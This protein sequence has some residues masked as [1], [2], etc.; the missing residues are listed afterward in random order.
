MKEVIFMKCP[1]VD[2]LSRYADSL[3]ND[4]EYNE[5]HIHVKGCHDCLHVVKAFEA[6]QLFLKE[7]LQT[8]S[9]PDDFASVILDQVEPYKPVRNKKIRWKP[10]L[11]PAAVVILTFGL[12]ASFSPSFAEWIGGL[13]ATEKVDEGLQIASDAGFVKRV[14]LEVTDKNVTFK[15][16]DV[17]ADS[18][19]VAFSYQIL[20]HASK[21]QDTYLDFG[22][23]KNEISAFD[24]N[25]NMLNISSMSWSDSDEY[26]LIEFSLREQESL[27]KITLKLN[28]VEINGVKGQWELD[29][30]VDLKE[31]LEHTTKL[32]LED[33]KTTHHGV[34]VQMKE[35]RFAPSSN[36]IIYETAF[37][38][39]E[40]VKIKE[41][42]QSLEENFG[43]ENVHSFTQYGT[44]IQYHLEDEQ[45][46]PIYYHNSFIDGKGHPSNLGMLQG[47]G[48]HTG[49]FG[50]TKWNESFIPAEEKLTFV[51]DGVI[52]TVPSDFSITIKP[53]ELKKKPVSFEYE[54]N[55]ITISDVK[56]Q[57][58]Y[59]LRKSIIPIQKETL[60]KIEMEGG[61]EALSAEL[62]SWMLEDENGKHYLTFHSGS[63]LDEKDENGRFKTTNELTVYNMDEVPEELTLHLIS[64]TRFHKVNEKWEVPLY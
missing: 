23:S 7:T 44:A 46:K 62:G 10:F 9:L 16:E 21:P 48:D 14:D 56:M 50:R 39:E 27:E 38:E 45:S 41:Q 2:M 30:P 20:N 52:K 28:L 15:V 13:F 51:L 3:L 18:S 40:K 31:S 22:D 29:I 63:I 42:V 24:Q 5:I 59:S 35:V 37:T 25:G 61:K 49:G 19:R 53:A 47:T 8:P 4:E 58:K 33:A 57:S 17:I 54:G 1:T 60:L 26:G 55:Y 12:T 64:V 32:A 34:E 11:L 43:K 36:E 6:E